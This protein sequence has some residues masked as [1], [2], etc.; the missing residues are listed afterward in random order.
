MSAAENRHP[1]ILL[2]NPPAEVPRE[3]YDTPN[4]PAVGIAYI[5]AYLLS[6]GMDCNVLDAKLAR[7]SLQQT[8]DSI[9]EQNPR[10]LGLTAMTHMVVTAHK[11]A[12]AVK[13]QCPETVIVLGGFHATFLPE[14]TLQEFAHFDYII[15]GEGEIAFHKLCAALLDGTDPIDIPGL[16]CRR[17]G[18]IRSNGR[19]ETV[20]DLDELGMPAWQLFPPAQMYPIVSHRG[21][22]F[23]CNFCSRP[24]GRKVRKRSVEHVIAEMKRNIDEFGC[25]ATDFYDET[26]TVQKPFVSGLC[27]SIVEHGIHHQTRFMAYV[28]ARTINEEIARLMKQA[29]FEEVGFG[30]ESGNPEIMRN[31]KKGVGA[32][33]VIRAARILRRVG[34]KFSAYFIIGHP[35]E[36]RATVRD[37]INLAVRVNPDSVAFGLMVPYPGT[38][39]WE[40]ATA[41]QGGYKLLSVNWADFNKQI[42]HAL[43]L[44]SLPRRTMERLQLQAYLEVYLRNLRLR[45]MA[46]A[47]WINRKRIAFILHKL[48]RKGKQAA[49]SSWLERKTLPAG[50]RS[51]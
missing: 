7:Q 15:S 34:L 6:H 30:V 19:G 47:I 12:A 5:A 28:H 45:E 17:D 24:Y 42:G 16:A 8:I 33:D 43:E 48:I 13:Q 14:R 46:Q 23:A 38:Q 20:D 37:T 9:I 50:A 22:P 27:R 1:S 25:R 2:V 39:I 4:Y 26:F 11:I 49:T 18:Q 31:M 29:N 3:C 10:I 35:H 51:T 21:C 32:D 41:G 44:D 36:T 40:L